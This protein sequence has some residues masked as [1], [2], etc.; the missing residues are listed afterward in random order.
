MITSWR[1]LT[2]IQL[3]D[4]RIIKDMDQLEFMHNNSTV[5]VDTK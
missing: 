2:W 4:I 3:K 5:L 1:L